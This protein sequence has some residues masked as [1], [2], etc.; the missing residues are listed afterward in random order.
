MSGAAKLAAYAAVLALVFGGAAVAGGAIDPDRGREET[1]MSSAHD[2]DTRAHDDTTAGAT[3]HDD[4]TRGAD[5]A[6]GGH[7][8]G[9]SGG[10]AS[11]GHGESGAHGAH[12]GAD[13]VRGLSVA[14]GGLRVVV[15][16]PELR[17]G[18][19]EQVSFRVV[20]ERG[21]TVR[22]FDVAHEQRMH[23]I[24][25][26]RDLT[27]FQHLHPEQAEDGSWTAPIRLDDAGSYRL[28]ADFT[29]GGEASTLAADL[30][31]DGAAD[32]RPLPAPAATAT[33]DGGETVALSGAD[34]LRAG[35]SA[36]LDFAIERDGEPVEVE[37]YLGASGHLVAL[38]D[39]DLAFLHVHPSGDGVSFE[40]AFPTAGAYRLFLQVK[41]DGA[42]RT[43]AFT[44]E[45]EP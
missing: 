26:R 14:D 41:V 15:E 29:R 39:G 45:V 25:A 6:S 28:F 40:T 2:T 19:A 10:S 43:A 36:T 27:G 17:R 37:P 18:T 35:E 7:G 8:A 1:T 20:D 24:V 21:E 16:R 3:G 5:A 42:V 11:G 9:A 44:V 33:T 34:Q 22:D 30:R 32:L 31:V 38:R 4:A 13:A 23:L 12:A